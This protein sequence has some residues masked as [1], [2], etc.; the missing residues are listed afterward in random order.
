MKFDEKGEDA[1]RSL[2]REANRIHNERFAHKDFRSGCW[3]LV[4]TICGLAGIAVIPS[5]AALPLLIVACIA[6]F[7]F[8][9]EAF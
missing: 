8:F 7:G 1:A 9:E 2:A 3:F 4:A 5:P 6:M